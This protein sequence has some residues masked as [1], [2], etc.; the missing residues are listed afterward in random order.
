MGILSQDKHPRLLDPA[1]YQRQGY[2]HD[3]WAKLQRP[4]D[5]IHYVEDRPPGP[6]RAVTWYENITAIQYQ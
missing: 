3:V 5:P 4:E 2:P 6:F 1:A